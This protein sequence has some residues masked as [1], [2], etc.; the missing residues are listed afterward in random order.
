MQ[1]DWDAGAPALRMPSL[2]SGNASWPLLPMLFQDWARLTNVANQCGQIA[3]FGRRGAPER[4][5][6]S[7]TAGGCV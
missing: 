1:A 3:S 4:Q 6:S 5:N 7:I 2:R